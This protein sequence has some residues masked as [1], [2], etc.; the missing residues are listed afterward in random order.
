MLKEDF[1]P[2]AIDQWYHRRQQD[3]EGQFYRKIASQGPR[4]D[5][6]QTTQGRYVCTAEGELLGFNNNRGPDRIGKLMRQA[7]KEF[8]PNSV[9]KV[10]PINSDAVDPKY[11]FGPPENGLILRVHSK[12]LGGYKPTE[13]WTSVFQQAIGRDNAWFTENEKARLLK[14]INEGGELPQ[15]IVQRIA[16][17]HLIDNTRGE[18]PRWAPEEIKAL[19]LS[20]DPSGVMRGKV[21]LETKDGKRGYEANLFGVIK[22]KDNEITQFDLVCRG[23]F[24]GTG[25]YTGF[26]PEGKFPLAIAFRIADGTDP[27]DA[28]APHGTKGWVDGYYQ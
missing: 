8:N 28:I 3:A 10:A 25:P 2:V 4:N 23:E 16:R 18:P 15:P 1:V 19:T 6:E 9:A 12:V 7:L 27:S 22:S 14:C 5:F 20:V 26:A 24:W 17:F 11:N 13:D 21:H